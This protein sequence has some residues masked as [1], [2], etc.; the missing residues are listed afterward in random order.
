M[1]KT[2]VYT[3]LALACFTIGC[4]ASGCTGSAVG[5]APV[6][7]SPTYKHLYD[8]NDGSLDVYVYEDL[9]TGN[10]VYL[11]SHGVSVTT[12]AA[13]GQIENLKKYGYVVVN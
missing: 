13:S 6:P 4:T 3:I 9:V 8:I 10:L 5:A 11:Q 12:P 2:K 1:T 7:P